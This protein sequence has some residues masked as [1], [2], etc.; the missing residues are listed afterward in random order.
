MTTSPSY[1]KD[2]VVRIIN[3]V[4]EKVSQSK[5]REH[6]TVYHQ[7][8][9]LQGI[10]EQARSEIGHTQASDIKD[11]HIP[12]ATDEL[13]AIVEATAAATGEILAACETIEGVPGVP[14]AAAEQITKIYEACTFQDITGQRISKVVK[15]LKTI[16]QKVDAL[17]GILG[18]G[19]GE[20]G[21]SAAADEDTRTGDAALLNGPQMAGQAISQEE[22]DRLLGDFD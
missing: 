20:T 9:E 19:E 1:Q 21:A 4:I 22:I 14:P 18:D 5:E 8:K 15:T 6:D 3:S 12:T 11:K 7:L 2:K 13:D 16:E 10:I 17:I